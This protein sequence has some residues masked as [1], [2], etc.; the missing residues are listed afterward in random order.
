MTPDAFLVALHLRGEADHVSGK[1]RGEVILERLPSL[2]AP[3]ACKE[4]SRAYRRVSEICGPQMLTISK[5]A[6]R[7]RSGGAPPPWH[8]G[9]PVREPPRHRPTDTDAMPSRD[10][11]PP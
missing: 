10:V 9:A 5:E 8:E 2:R 6:R 1:D 7:N 4:G 11:R 3:S